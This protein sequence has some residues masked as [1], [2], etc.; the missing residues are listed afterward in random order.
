MKRVDCL[1]LTVLHI[2]CDQFKNTFDKDNFPMF[3]LHL[4]KHT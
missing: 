3:I 1:Q 4:I 2:D